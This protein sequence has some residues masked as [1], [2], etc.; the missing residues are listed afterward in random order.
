MDVKCP[1]CEKPDL[2]ITVTLLAADWSST[3]LPCCWLVRLLSMV[4]I[5]QTVS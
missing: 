4:L 2:K 1:L 3:Q 5:G